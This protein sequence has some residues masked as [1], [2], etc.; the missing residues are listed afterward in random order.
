MI[1]VAPYLLA[2]AGGRIARPADGP[3]MPAV[4]RTLWDMGLVNIVLP[5]DQGERYRLN[6]AGEKAAQEA[7][8]ALLAQQAQQQAKPA[9]PSA[10][11]AA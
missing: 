5:C 4:L 6:A 9:Q 10:A 1:N 7:A 8:T 11:A 3:E 2:M